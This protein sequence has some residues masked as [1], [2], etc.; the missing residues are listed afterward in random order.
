M[1]SRGISAAAFRPAGIFAMV[2]VVLFIASTV[3]IS[4]PKYRTRITSYNVCYTKLL[5]DNLKRSRRQL[6]RIT[7]SNKVGAVALADVYRQQV[8]VGNDELAVISAQSTYES[9]KADLI[10]YLGVEFNESY[11]F[12]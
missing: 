3:S 2:A 10:A 12:V 6:E 7:E 8:Q 11:N 4:Q 5:R 1:H 9:S